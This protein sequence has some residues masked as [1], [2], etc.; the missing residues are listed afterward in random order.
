[1]EKKGAGRKK[2]LV[3]VLAAVVLVLIAAYLIVRPQGVKTYLVIGMDNYGS[4]EETGRN[5]VTMLVQLDFDNRR[6]SAATFARD[7]FVNNE[8][9]KPV[10]I[11]TLVKSKGED[12]LADA[13]ERNFGVRTD[14]WFRLNFTTVV[15]LVDAI[16]GVEVELSAKE[17]NYINKDAGIYDEYPLSEG[18]CLLNGGQALSLARCRKL[19]NDLGRGDRQTRLV[20][21]L[22]QRAKHIGAGEIMGLLDAL[23]YA[24]RSSLTGAEQAKL[25]AQCLW[26][27]GADVQRIGLP[28][29]GTWGYGEKN[30]TSGVV[31]N[32]EKNREQLLDALGRE[33]Q[34]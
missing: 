1:M 25:L 26:L 32:I 11:N 34:Q 19:D 4:L 24:W 27:R 8:N 17:V 31:A 9:G 3:I 18:V 6:I 15:L 23:G 2:R 22:A 12:G 5:D 16:G 33:T 13:I 29:D 28:F 30:G 20:A 21:A 10:K 7:M 14:G